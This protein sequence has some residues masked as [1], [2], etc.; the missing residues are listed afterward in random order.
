MARTPV[1]Q[2]GNRGS[3]PLGAISFL[4]KMNDFKVLIY[5]ISTLT[6]TIIGVGF[7]SLPYI[8]LQVGFPI[9]FIY[10]LFL[11][12]VIA[13]IH[14]FFGELAIRTPDLKRFPGFAAYYL[15]NWGKKIAF[16]SSILG[17]FGAIL[18]YLIVG[19]EFLTEIFSST[20]GNS[21]LFWTLIYFSLGAILVFFGIK[22]IAKIELFWLLLLFLFLVF[23]FFEG[24]PK[25]KISNLFSQTNFSQ[26]FLPYGPILFS[27]W[28]ADL[29]PE[30]EEMLRE[31]K[32]LLKRVILISFLIPIFIY[33]LFIYLILGICGD[34]TTESALTG[35]KTFL[36]KEAVTAIL[37]IG[38]LTSFT[39]FISLALTLKNIFWYDLKINK[40]LAWAITCFVP[41]FLFLAG[42]KKFISIISFSG[43]IMLG[44]DGILI[45]LMYKKVFQDQ[46]SKLKR[47]TINFLITILIA[48]IFYEIIYF[49]K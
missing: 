43:A 7:F 25:I 23:I 49:G 28:G 14:I 18:A 8:T 38:V 4:S 37:F 30:I 32:Y 5:T 27:L 48:G 35:L 15:G 24:F 17:I 10:F 3:N 6:G 40:N 46:F 44:I 22:I 34:K 31:K 39:S 20:F 26:I 29:I 19:G 21:N 47:A 42:I 1:S 41:L 45:L 16:F 12:T 11:G 33:L 13:L 36:G 9:I 2:A